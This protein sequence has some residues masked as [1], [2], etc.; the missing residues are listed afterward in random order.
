MFFKKTKKE[1]PVQD[2]K[3]KKP[4]YWQRVIHGKGTVAEEWPTAEE[5]WNDPN[6]QKAI[7]NHNELIQKRNRSKNNQSG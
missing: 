4:T 7:K 6:I 2:K 5:L 1:D 3:D